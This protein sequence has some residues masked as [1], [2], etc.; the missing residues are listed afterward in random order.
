[1]IGLPDTFSVVDYYSIRLR[2]CF[3]QCLEMIHKNNNEPRL[4]NS[5]PTTLQFHSTV[6]TSAVDTPTLNSHINKQHE[7]IFCYKIYA[8]V[9]IASTH[10]GGVWEWSVQKWGEFLDLK[11]TITGQRKLHNRIFVICT[12]HLKGRDHW[13]KCRLTVG[14]KWIFNCTLDW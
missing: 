12:F 11:K 10:V 2:E 14:L 7:Y 8:L 9:Y 13:V 6:I 1:M 5:R 4:Y 3:R